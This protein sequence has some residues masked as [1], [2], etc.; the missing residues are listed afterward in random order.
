METTRRTGD[1]SVYWY[2]FRTVRPLIFVT[3]VAVHALGAFTDNFPQVWLN[4]WTA[5]GGRGLLLPLSIYTLF[6]LASSILSVLRIRVVFLDI[7]PRSAIRLHKTI[8]AVVINA[9]Q[10]FFS[11]TDTG[12]TLNRFSQ[13][14]SLVD[15]P[16]P[17]ALLCVSTALFNLLAQLGLIATGSSYMGLTIPFTLATIWAVQHVYLQTSRQLRYLDLE[18]K[19]PLYSHFI[20]TLDGLP[21][22]RALHWKSAARKIQEKHLDYSQRPYYTLLC[23]QRW[24]NLVLDLMV[25]ALATIVVAL[26]LHLRQTTTA[27]LLGIAL[28]NILSVNQSLSGLVTYWTSLETSLG[29][30]ARVKSFKETT[31]SEIRNDHHYQEG[32]APPGWP[33]TG[34]IAFDRVSVTYENGAQTLRDVSLCIRPGQKIGICGRTGR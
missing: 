20:E 30:I 13:D 25:T 19:S 21:T 34:A 4:W 22:I 32:N 28:N 5:D 24:L 12:M 18:N 1:L 27:G 3:F 29:A 8:L 23:V 2:Y 31:P 10:S 9:P 11:S 16:L 6:A 14:M 7:M 26:A 15:M 17:G 33:Q